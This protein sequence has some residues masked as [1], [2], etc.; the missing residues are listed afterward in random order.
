MN[1]N[2][3]A[4]STSPTPQSVWSTLTRNERIEIRQML[5]I[6]ASNALRFHRGDGAD[7]V[8]ADRANRAEDAAHALWRGHGFQDLQTWQLRELVS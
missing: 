5:D 7:P 1:K 2:N 8:L 4:T 3:T 6:S